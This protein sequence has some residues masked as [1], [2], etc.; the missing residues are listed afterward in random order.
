M[1]N[2]GWHSLMSSGHLPET[3][4][5]QAVTLNPAANFDIQDRGLILPGQRADLAIF[6]NNTNRLLATIRRGEMIY[7]YEN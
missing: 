7:S 6:E 3:R 4:A 1:L 5:A 2:T